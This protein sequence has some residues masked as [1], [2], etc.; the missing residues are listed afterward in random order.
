MLIVFILMADG[1]LKHP[2]LYMSL[3]LKSNRIE[4]Y[5]RLS[6]VMAKGNYE[7]WIKFFLRG[8][9]RK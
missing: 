5:N 8:C 2:V 6:E 7:Q 1:I 3:Y 4:Y 9:Y